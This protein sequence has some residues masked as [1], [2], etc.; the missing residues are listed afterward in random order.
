[1]LQESAG[2]VCVISFRNKTA[3][4][5][6]CAETEGFFVFFLSFFFFFFSFSLSFCLSG[7]DVKIDL[8]F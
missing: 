2:I 3:Q 5:A 6:D 7:F 4:T 8:R 1:M